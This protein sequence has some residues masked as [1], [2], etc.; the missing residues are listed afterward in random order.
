VRLLALDLGPG[1][2]GGQRQTV[3]VL[4]GLAARGH[5]VRLL[6]RRGSPLASDARARG[7]DT[8]EVPP[9]SEA[10]PAL[11][12]AV[13]REA[14]TFRPGIVY[15]GDARG[16]GAA[17]FGRAAANAPLVVHRRVVFAPG[18]SPLSRLK[19]RAAARYLAVSHA[20][21]ASLA[22]AGVP[23][24]KIAIVPDGL[25]ADAFRE[26]VAPPPPPFR[27]VH[28]G[29]FDGL[30]GQDVVVE[31]LARLAAEGIDAHAL[32]LGSGPARAAVEALA[33]SRGVADRCTFAGQVENA[34]EPFAASH[35]ML[36]PSASEGGPLVLVEA[37]AAGCPVVGHDVGGSREMVAD[38]S[39]GVLVPTLELSAWEEA[40]R[41]VLLDTARRARLVEAGRASA[42]ERRIEKTVERVEAELLRTLGETP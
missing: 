33:A 22:A 39:A 19:Y 42:A 31:T 7:L 25:P 1:M 29:A 17:V 14:R 20:V 8:A 11:L 35:L 12:L 9:G 34:G 24:E 37:M 13:A 6:A 30:K 21:A 4:A 3:L 18:R 2:R 27:L 41:G 5:S 32:F 16:H 38:G 40:V 10:S 15:A 26:N 23:A 28:A 36:L